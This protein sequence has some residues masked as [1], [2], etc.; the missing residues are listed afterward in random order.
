LLVISLAGVAG[1]SWQWRRAERNAKAERASSQTAREQLWNSLLAQ[2][3]AGRLSGQFGSKRAGLEAIAAAARIRPAP[4]LRDEAIAHL[5]LFDIQPDPRP[6]RM[7]KGMTDLSFDAD[8]ERYA[9]TDK[10]AGFLRVV[11]LADDVELAARPLPPGFSDHPRFSPLGKHLTMNSGRNFCV[12]DASTGQERFRLKD[13]RRAQVSPDDTTLA[14]ISSER[15]VRFFDAFSGQPLPGDFSPN[16]TTENLVWSPDGTFIALGD[17]RTIDV[18]NWRLGRRIAPPA[19]HN[20]TF[21]TSLVWAG[22]YIAAGDDQG[23]IFLWNARTKKSRRLVGHQD[24]LKFLSFNGTGSILA[25]WSNDGITRIWNTATGRQ[26]L[27]TASG[28]VSQFSKDGR[29]IGYITAHGW[30]VWRVDEPQG[31]RVVSTGDR[32]LELVSTAEVS[33]DGRCLL[34]AN[35]PVG[36]QMVD[37]NTLRIFRFGFTNRLRVA[38]F[39]PDG[40]TIFTSG[41][42]QG[43]MLSSLD[44]STNSAGQPE[45]MLGLPRTLPGV[46]WKRSDSAGLSFDGKLAGAKTGSREVVVVRLDVTNHV[47]WLRG[48]PEAC[49]PAFSADHRWVVTASEGGGGPCLWEADTGNFVRLLHAHAGNGGA[50]FSPDGQVLVTSDTTG[51]RFY[52]VATWNVMRHLPT[53]LGAVLAGCAAFTPDSRLVAFTTG[54]RELGL[55]NSH[56]GE[57]LATLI[58]PEVR[59]INEIRFSRN[60]HLLAVS[61]TTDAVDLWDIAL[62][63][64]ELKKLG[65]GLPR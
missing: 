2:A 45:P 9:Y 29:R 18:W 1:I 62:L 4:G 34:I 55:A 17:G 38:W 12:V 59:H 11:R 13:V 52:D 19:R 46:E 7:T 14:I 31:F 22:E 39:M 21:F 25:S 8:V 10:T 43:L 20:A 35:P 61:T 30:G 54:T 15:M 58:S 42:K 6:H 48:K 51:V 16:S 23:G 33:R 63:D 44:F 65:L 3:R 60:G 24:H 40:Q 26:L 47:T 36:L 28:S 57:V 56:T 64:E 37:L 27:S 53:E 41:E 5:A 50:Q 32:T 49:R